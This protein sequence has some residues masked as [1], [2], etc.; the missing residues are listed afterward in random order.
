MM[1][2]EGAVLTNRRFLSADERGS[3]TAIT[4]D[5]A[6]V[7]ARNAYDTFGAPAPANLGLFGYTGQPLLSGAELWNFRARAYHPGLGRFLQTDP[8]G[9][10]G[11]MN[12]YAYVGN[13]PVNFVDPLG[14][15]RKADEEIIVTAP[16]CKEKPGMGRCLMLVSVSPIE[17]LPTFFKVEI[18]ALADTLNAIA[19]DPTLQKIGNCAS[20]QF[21]LDDFGAAAA[22]A[23]GANVIPTQGKLGAATKNTSVA[24]IAASRVFGSTKLPIA[25]PTITGYPF[26]GQGMRIVATK[27]AARVAARAVPVIGTALLAVDVASIGLCVASG[28]GG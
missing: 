3:I 14:L 21:G 9:M 25:V 10:E 11:G 20:R 28:E 13:D 17:A 6:G 7:L 16:T 18:A 26:V 22:V 12:L 24:S 5:A 15:A 23:A 8:I 19:T 27:S 2:Y 4:N 1:W